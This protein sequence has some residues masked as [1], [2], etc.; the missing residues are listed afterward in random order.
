V[1]ENVAP[2]GARLS[3]VLLETPAPPGD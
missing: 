2:H 3:V 1:A